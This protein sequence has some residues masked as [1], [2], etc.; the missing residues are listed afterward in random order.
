MKLSII[1]CGKN[2][3]Y[4][5]NFLKRLQLNLDK[6]NDNIK[7]LNVSDIEIIVVDWG[8]EI[9]LSDVLNTN[10]FEFIKFLH[11]PIDIGNV[12][13]PDS[14]FSIVHSFNAGFLRS[15]GD[16]IFFI[17]GDSYVP[18]ESF[19]KIY[20]L[21]N[22]TGH[23][24]FYWASRYHL[25]HEIHSSVSDILELDNV[26]ENFEFYK[27]NWPHEKVDLGHFQGAAM[28]LLLDRNICDETSLYYE[29]LNRWGWL[30]IE[31]H[32]RI[33]RNYRCL[34]DLEDLGFPF[35]HLDHHQ[36][37]KTGNNGINPTISSVSF[38]ANDNN[39]GLKYENLI[40]Y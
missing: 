10:N 36:I 19:K 2:D 7:K 17:D 15:K 20:D 22:N 38:R 34:G 16:Y 6:L 32:N 27:N 1:T 25:P 31:I 3:G 24:T 13:S 21:I 35:F 12:Y 11:I 40:L 14:S 9:R 26:I 4:A 23:Y 39:W 5:G 30:D 33:S 8:S 28:G 29:K 18:Y 37:Q